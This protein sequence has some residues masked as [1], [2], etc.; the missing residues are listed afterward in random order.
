MS[1]IRRPDVNVP[2]ALPR[3]TSRQYPS[4][5]R[6]SRWRREI[7]DRHPD[8]ARLGPPDRH[9]LVVVEIE[10]V[11]ATQTSSTLLPLSPAGRLIVPR[12]TP[13]PPRRSPGLADGVESTPPKRQP[14]GQLRG[15][16]R[17]SNRGHSA[18][19]RRAGSR[20]VRG[21]PRCRTPSTG[22][23]NLVPDG[24]SPVR[25]RRRGRPDRRARRPGSRDPARLRRHGRS[26]GHH[27]RGCRPPLAR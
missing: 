19:V 5:H 1:W 3:S 14:M 8:A 6:A 4:S 11:V 21:A 15:L 18:Y 9:H 12:T 25:D 17:V 16:A 2:L 13:R 23:A 24:A 27:A 7:D 10:P 22:H 20:S 26:G